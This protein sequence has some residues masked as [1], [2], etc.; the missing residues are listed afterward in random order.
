[1]RF[2]SMFAVAVSATV[3]SPTATVAGPAMMAAVM[4]MVAMVATMVVI[5]EAE[6]QRDRW[7]DI[8]RIPIV[9]IRIIVGI[10]IRVRVRRRVGVS[11]IRIV[12]TATEAACQERGDRKALYCSDA[13][14]VHGSSRK[15]RP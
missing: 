10:R 12:D 1:M 7:P 14:G 6:V 3:M 5:T 8:G 15:R 13:S 2:R 11:V 4:T 9:S